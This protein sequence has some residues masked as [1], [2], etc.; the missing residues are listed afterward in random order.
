ML[1]ASRVPPD[2][3]VQTAAARASAESAS[4]PASCRVSRVTPVA[5]TNASADASATA[6]CSSVRKTRV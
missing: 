1:A 6:P 2:Q 3:P 5:K 4:R